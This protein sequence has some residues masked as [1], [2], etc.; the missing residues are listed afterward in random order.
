MKLYDYLEDEYGY[1][2]PIFSE[3]L[4]QNLDMNSNTLRVYL[5]RLYRAGKLNKV[6]DGIYFIPN[7]N[8]ILKNPTL[9]VEKIIIKKYINKETE[10]IGYESGIAFANRLKLTTQNPGVITIVTNE[11]KSNKRIVE[12]YKR[13]V[14]LKKPKVKI[15][16]RNYKV[17]QV[18][19][20][21]NEFDR[22]SVEPIEVASKQ[23]CQYLKGVKLDRNELE[24][25]LDQYPIKTR[26]KIQQ[27]E[28]YDEITR[29]QRSF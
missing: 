17:L 1:N 7:P 14:A 8:S 6:K 4:N 28:V 20:L 18:L 5:T 22:L 9:S 3:D 21:L 29:G 24:S 16:N 15:N 23:I 27:T 13:R 19:D 26:A 25:Y 12:F 11:E 10:V 2:E